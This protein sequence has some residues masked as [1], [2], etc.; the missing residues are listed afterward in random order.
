MTRSFKFVV[1][2]SACSIPILTLAY[3]LFGPLELARA[4]KPKKPSF[5]TKASWYGGKFRGRRTA[6]G[7]RFN[8]AK[9]TAAS[10]N[11]PMGSK[12]R[13]ENPRN[14]N[15]IDVVINDRGPF[16]KGRGID[17]SP[18]AAKQ[19]G[20]TGVAPV[21][22]Y[23]NK[24]GTPIKTDTPSDRSDKDKTVASTPKKVDTQ[25]ERSDKDQK[26]ASNQTKAESQSESSDK[27]KVDEKGQK[28]KGK[29]SRLFKKIFGS[30]SD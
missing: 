9:L 3:G 24:A 21:V 8:P 20:V 6:S 29:L 27:G 22:C 1:R 15:K 17:L 30:K 23:P 10:P 13:V 28:K 25:V 18:A 7:E 26:L 5:T 14:G 4:E 2:V 12:V 19:L 16:V 11:L